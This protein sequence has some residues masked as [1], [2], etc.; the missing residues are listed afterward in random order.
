MVGLGLTII[1]GLM[2]IVNFAHGELYMLGGYSFFVATSVMRVSPYMGLVLSILVTACAGFAIERLL[3]S[4]IHTKKV[5]RK[6]EYAIL[7]TFGLS[8]FLQNAALIVFGAFPLAPPSFA[9]GLLTISGITVSMDRV[10]VTFV[11]LAALALTLLLV[12]RTSIGRAMRAVSQDREAALVVGIDA[13]RIYTM[14]FVLGCAMA[15]V[16]GAV[17]APVFLVTPTMGTFPLIKGFV[18]I[19]LG[20]M[21]SIPG[22]IIGA[23]VLGLVETFA[24]AY[25]P[26]VRR[27]FAYR[28]VYGLVILVVVLVMKP[29]GLLGEKIRKA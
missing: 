3:I 24:A 2:K 17:M 20:G 23:I 13:N 26:D 22:S 4:P 6:D 18:I 28:D 5:E 11:A 1:F 15:G 10:V 21:G 27:A 29:S 7:I 9:P 12:Y 25:I 14:G 19:V 16:A 8:I